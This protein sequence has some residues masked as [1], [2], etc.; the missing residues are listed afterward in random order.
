[1]SPRSE[2]KAHLNRPP[3][4]DSWRTSDLPLRQQYN[5]PVAE[6]W[7]APS[8]RSLKTWEGIPISASQTSPTNGCASTVHR[9]FLGAASVRVR[10]ARMQGSEVEPVVAS[11]PEGRSSETTGQDWSFAHW[12]HRLAAASGSPWNPYPNRASTISLGELVGAASPR[13]APIPVLLEWTND[14]A[15]RVSIFL[16]AGPASR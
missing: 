5:G 8:P 1:M 12:I 3:K 7:P 14:V 6:N 10:A 13:M 15:V 2:R 11:N 4:S 9:P 16:E